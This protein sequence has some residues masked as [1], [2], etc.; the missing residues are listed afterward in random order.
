MIY[1]QTYTVIWSVCLLLRPTAVAAVVVTARPVGSPPHDRTPPAPSTLPIPDRFH[2][3]TTKIFGQPPYNNQ[4]SQPIQSVILFIYLLIYLYIYLVSQIV[5]KSI[6]IKS[7]M[8]KCK[9]GVPKAST[10]LNLPIIIF[11][12]TNGAKSLVTVL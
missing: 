8:S 3:G 2:W 9:N 7:Q 6:A 11:I 4:P 1:L 5:R 10:D 12:K